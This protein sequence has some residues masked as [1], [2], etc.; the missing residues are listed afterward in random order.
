MLLPGLVA[1]WALPRAPVL[2]HGMDMHRKDVYI[3][4]SM[5]YVTGIICILTC[6]YYQTYVYEMCVGVF[7]GFFDDVFVLRWRTKL[8]MHALLLFPTVWHL[9]WWPLALLCTIFCANA[10]NILAGINGV[11]VIQ[12]LTMSMGFMWMDLLDGREDILPGLLT[13]TSLALLM[14]N[15]YPASLFV[16]DTFTTYGGLAIA[17]MT[18]TRRCYFATAIMMLPQG[19]NFLFSLPQLV[20]LAPCPRH[21]LPGWDAERDV[22]VPSGP[23]T[24]LNKLLHVLGP[25]PEAHL[26]VIVWALQ[27]I[28]VVLALPLRN[29][30]H[31]L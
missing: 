12:V 7:M 31:P 2:S 19:V 29:I 11:E 6:M 30:V 27:C 8:I 16:G 13:S 20:G 4:E 18:F 3:P 5:G 22:L 17:W 15:R 21:R 10:V 9:W 25:M 14:F 23:G 24:L 28:S 26:M 1:W